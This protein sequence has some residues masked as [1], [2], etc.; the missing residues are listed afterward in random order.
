MLLQRKTNQGE[1]TPVNSDGT[2]NSS[3]YGR[4]S[5][6]PQYYKIPNC[7][8]HKLYVW[9]KWGRATTRHLI[10]QLNILILL[11]EVVVE[12][13][14]VVVNHTVDCQH[15][16]K[17]WYFADHCKYW[18]VTCSLEQSCTVWT[19]TIPLEKGSSN[20]GPPAWSLHS[21]FILLRARELLHLLLLFYFLKKRITCS[22]WGSHSGDYKEYHLLGL[23]APRS[24]P[25]FRRNVLLQGLG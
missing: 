6:K 25:T 12:K 16:Q 20:S 18:S 4:N 8:Y 1:T 19:W 9:L 23:N 10:F 15:E 21:C 17:N 22:I 2:A 3:P 13:N 11:Y 14:V 24:P 5:L 7:R